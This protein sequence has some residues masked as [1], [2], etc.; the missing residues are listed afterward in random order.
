MKT[1]LVYHPFYL[2]HDTGPAHPE[3]PSRL[4]AILRKLKNTGLADE[5]ELIEPE[6][7]SVDDIALVH[8]RDYIA[9]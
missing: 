2:R 8:K 9:R 3:R 4:R 7:A 1:A 5:L 6:K